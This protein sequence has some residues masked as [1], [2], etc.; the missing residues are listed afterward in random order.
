MFCVLTSPV[1]SR[2]WR[3]KLRVLLKFVMVTADVPLQ[4]EDIGANFKGTKRDKAG[5][6]ASRINT[7]LIESTKYDS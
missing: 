6:D 5:V 4:C 3:S 2:T 7:T 1:G